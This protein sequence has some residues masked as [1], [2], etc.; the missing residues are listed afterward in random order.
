MTPRSPRRL[1]LRRAALVLAAASLAAPAAAS[2]A[3]TSIVTAPVKVRDYQLQLLI[4]DSAT[5][6]AQI[7]FTR[8]SGKALQLHSYSFSQ[9][10]AATVKGN[11]ASGKVTAALGKYGAIKLKLSKVGKGKKG[12]VPKGCTGT[13]GTTRTGTLSGTFK[14]V[15]DTT[16]FKTVSLK[17]LK[18]TLM[19]GGSLDCSGAGD[20]GTGVGDSTSGL[21]LNV[22][23]TGAGLQSFTALKLNGAISQQAM[24]MEDDTATAPASIMHMISA[25]ATD[26]AFSAA[27][28]LSSAGVAGVA[29]FFSGAGQFSSDG[30]YGGMAAG[31]LGGT[32]VAKFDSI[33]DQP[34]GGPDQT[35]MLR[36]S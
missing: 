13:P 16:Y 12:V 8:S 33:G 34:I 31:T 2:A 27:G 9:G 22:M 4:S 7:M 3:G 15:A 17:K 25:P 23:K 32:L 5:D 6:S 19:K 28:D 21:T 36:Q 11:L 14:L 18:A 1:R 20:G 10:V 35:A 29:P 30:A 24:V 26:A